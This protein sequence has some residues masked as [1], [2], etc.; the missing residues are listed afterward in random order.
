MNAKRIFFNI[1]RCTCSNVEVN[2]YTILC[3][4]LC[5]VLKHAFTLLIISHS[6]DLNQ[7]SFLLSYMSVC[8]PKKLYLF[9]SFP[10][11]PFMNQSTKL[12][13]KLPCLGPL[14]IQLWLCKDHLVWNI[15]TKRKYYSF[16]LLVKA[17]L[18][19]E[20]CKVI[21]CPILISKFLIYFWFNYW[22]YWG[23][24]SLVWVYPSWKCPRCSPPFW[25]S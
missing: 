25:K 18:V 17:E 12:Q 11:E 24:L 22:Q 7:L 20:V 23:L 8:L 10:L 14:Y 6:N 3:Y 2:F 4:S 16:T 15:Q 5:A 13:K 21:T 9:L 19:S 1:C